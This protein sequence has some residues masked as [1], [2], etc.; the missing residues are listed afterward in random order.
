LL[1]QKRSRGRGIDSS[2]HPYHHPDFVLPRHKREK[3][4]KLAEYATVGS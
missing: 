1:E 4:P 2:A 3:Y